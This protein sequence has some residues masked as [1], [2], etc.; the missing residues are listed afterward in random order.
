VETKDESN[1]RTETAVR[2][3]VLIVDDDPLICDVL[4]SLFANLGYE[5]VT[6]EDGE[7]A[8]D[9]ISSY[10]LSAS[11]RAPSICPSS[12]QPA[13]TT[14]LHRRSVPPGASF[15][16]KA[17]QLGAVR[18]PCAICHPQRPNRATCAAPRPKRL[19]PAR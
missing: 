10:T 9:R 17:D 11:I 16:T 6:A 3:C 19:P 13:M 4:A 12:F 5:T 18:L 15:V 2:K 1:Q 8:C 7:A 14:A